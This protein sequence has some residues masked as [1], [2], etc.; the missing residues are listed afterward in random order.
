MEDDTPTSPGKKAA[1]AVFDPPPE[2]PLADLKPAA[3]PTLEVPVRLPRRR[4]W[5]EK[6]ATR[7]DL[8]I[9]GGLF[10]AFVLGGVALL[11]AWCR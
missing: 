9:F 6:L 11:V 2:P 10:L 4:R 7:G 8:L 5:W 1:L 3:D